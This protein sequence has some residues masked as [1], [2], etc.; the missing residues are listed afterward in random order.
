MPK[1]GD[2]LTIAGIFNANTIYPNDGEKFHCCTYGRVRK[3]IEGMY[4]IYN[5]RFEESINDWV[6]FQYVLVDD[7]DELMSI[8]E[9]Q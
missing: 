9:N 4:G 5:L 6:V 1:T 7:S 3:V 8:L 2:V